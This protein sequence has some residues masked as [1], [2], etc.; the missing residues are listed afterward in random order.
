MSNTGVGDTNSFDPMCFV[1]RDN[2]GNRPWNETGPWA[3]FFQTDFDTFK[4]FSNVS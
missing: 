4:Y 3:L 1:F 2:N